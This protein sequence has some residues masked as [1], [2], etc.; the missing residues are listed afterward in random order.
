MYTTGQSG[1][2]ASE[3][4][5]DMIEPWRTLGYHNLYADPNLITQSGY[6]LLELIP[7]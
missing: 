4:Y 3:H 1:H 2:P 7:E 6:K 5:S